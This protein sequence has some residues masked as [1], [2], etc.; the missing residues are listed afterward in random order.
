MLHNLAQVMHCYHYNIEQSVFVS[1]K[2]MSDINIC[3]EKLSLKSY[4]NT[5]SDS[6]YGK[7]L[8]VR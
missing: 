8:I 2:Y 4:F 5:K 7:R 6:I 3:N 1:I